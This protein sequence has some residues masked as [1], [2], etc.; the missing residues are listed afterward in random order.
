MK[1]NRKIITNRPK[2]SNSEILKQKQPFKELIKNYYSASFAGGSGL[3]SFL[4]WGIGGLTLLTV[5]TVIY[6]SE[7]SPSENL[8]EKVV[9][10]QNDSLAHEGVVE[11]EITYERSIKPPYAD[12]IHYESYR[13]RNN[14]KPRTITTKNGSVI[15][16]P[17]KAFVDENGKEVL[18][19]I[20]IE[21]RDFYNPVDFFLS[22]IPM[23]YD[24]AGVNYTFTSAGMF[25]INAMANGKKLYL[26]EGKKI[27]IDLVS[28]EESTYNFYNY[29]TLH[30][31]WAYQYS[32]SPEDITK[33]EMNDGQKTTAM[34]EQRPL[35]NHISIRKSGENSDTTFDTTFDTEIQM[36]MNAQIIVSNVDK[37]NL[38]VREPINYS[39]S[40]NK[41]MLKN[42]SYEG[43]NSLMLEID[44]KQKFDPNNYSVVWDKVELVESDTGLFIQL[45]KDKII[46]AY[47]VK[48]V[49]S[50]AN[51]DKAV[52]DYEKIVEIRKGQIVKA[53]KRQQERRYI[54][55]VTNNWVVTRRIQVTN[56]GLFNCDSPLPQP[57]FA[58]VGTRHIKD[59]HGN[60][61]YY[62]QLYIAQLNQNTLWQYPNNQPWYYSNQLENIAWFITQN[63]DLAIIYP[64]KFTTKAEDKYIATI[65]NSKEGINHLYKMIN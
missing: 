36:D 38:E 55:E 9:V 31:E 28:N 2:I 49:V 34:I 42:T 8:N 44:T 24:S 48:P 4:G 32:E 6:F 7:M 18:K 19:N 17:A 43:I 20:K 41:E 65:Y 61:L 50:L 39:F 11:P 22:G 23:D 30:N 63:G 37:G 59:D 21:Y 62:S 54:S 46:H 16:L 58:S 1:A 47:A 27:D 33:V 56:L 3:S 64:D 15:N 5:A 52:K 45:T 51:Y 10:Q 40:A 35:N 26:K 25:E 14:K 53:K 13:V 29:D 57:L 12:R 60:R